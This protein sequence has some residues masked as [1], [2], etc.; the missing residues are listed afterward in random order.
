MAAGSGG[1]PGAGGTQDTR[2][3]RQ[4]EGIAGLQ[5]ENAENSLYD[6]NWPSYPLTPASLTIGAGN[7]GVTYTATGYY[8]GLIGNS[9][10]VAHVTS[11]TGTPLSV[12]VSGYAVTVHLATDGS[13]VATS[14]AAQVA[15]AVNGAAEGVSGQ[16][17]YVQQG[18]QTLVV[19][20]LPGTGAS[21]AV[22][23][24]ATNLSGASAATVTTFDSGR[25][26]GV[27]PARQVAQVDTQWENSGLDPW[28]ALKA[29]DPSK[30]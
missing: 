3:F 5:T 18:T 4:E 14:T 30:W 12:N 11:G 19:A 10:T 15:A 8:G 23:Q 16:G 17:G 6:A 22:A 2:V 24:A 27:E 9:I 13:G 21:N 7:A 26:A 25:A 28:A 29:A 1:A 20:S